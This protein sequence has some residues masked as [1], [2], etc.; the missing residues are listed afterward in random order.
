MTVRPD[1]SI[2]RFASG[3]TVGLLL[4]GLL[5]PLAFAHQAGT[6]SA[7]STALDTG[8]SPGPAASGGTADTRAGGGT[9][10]AAADGPGGRS[11]AA[12]VASSQG[13]VATGASATAASA[14]AGVTD[15][16]VTATTVKLGVGLL[17]TGGLSQAG[18]DVVASTADQQ[19]AW[20]AFIDDLNSRG[21][22][23]GRKVEAAFHKYDILS[24]A[25][26]RAACLYWTEEAKVF[27][28]VEAFGYF[29]PPVLCITQEHQ[30]PFLA[31]GGV[32]IPADYFTKS[33]SRLFVFTQGGDRMMRN[34]AAELGGLKGFKGDKVGIVDG[35]SLYSPQTVDILQNA[36][37]KAGHSV[38]R[39]STLAADMDTA[40][41]QVPLEVQQMRV[42]G[43][44]EVILNTDLVLST[45]WVNAAASQGWTPRY[46]AGDWA[47]MSGD[48]ST[49]G[50]PAA[51]D[52]SIAFTVTRNGD[53]RAGWPEPATEAH[54]RQIYEGRTGKKLNR[55]GSTDDNNAY[56]D[57]IAPCSPLALFEAGATAVGRALTRAALS[58]AIQALGPFAA[59]SIGGGSFRPGKFDAPDLIRTEVWDKSC[60][61]WRP[62][63]TFHPGAF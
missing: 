8:T 44:T 42:A 43:A 56:L 48:F 17:D 53:W 62:A 50:M 5:T 38:V 30:T 18:V 27:A 46:Y 58:A 52:G 4:A 37:T 26:M 16:G 36:L 60:T 11:G 2:G 39:R 20:Q 22:V 35:G 32:G 34:L 55:S 51:F 1:R 33:Q 59:T 63:G 24:E 54:C 25:S 15:I 23:A 9:G 10:G 7:S 14:A 19:T 49:I 21:G 12:G 13:G 40:A 6:T 28:V 41:S 57:A 3:L 29:G 45:Q 61:C 31:R 47:A